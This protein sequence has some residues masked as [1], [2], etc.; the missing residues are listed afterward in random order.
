MLIVAAC[1]PEEQRF[2][3]GGDRLVDSLQN[4]GYASVS[5]IYGNHRPPLRAVQFGYATKTAAED[6]LSPSLSTR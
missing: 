6:H 3:G 5:E 4:A 1:S 2:I